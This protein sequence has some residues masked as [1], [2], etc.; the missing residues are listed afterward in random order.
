MAEDQGQDKTEQP[1][2]RKLEEAVEQGNVAKSRELNSVAVLV[3]VMIA[4]KAFS[5]YTANALKGFMTTTYQE[6]SFISI[7]VESLPK[8]TLL[9]LSVLAKVTLPII[10]VVLVFAMAANYAQ[11]GFIF[12]KKALLPKFSKINPLSGLKR[13]FSAQSLVELLKGIIKIV[14]L[15]FISYL[16]IRKHIPE[17]IALPA[18][19]AGE[20]T[21]FFI[22]ILFE[23]TLKIT[24]ALLVMAVADFAWQKYDHLKQLKMTKQEVK[25]EMKQQEGNPLVKSKIRS[26]QLSRARSRMLKAV[27]EATVV[28]TNPTTY[29]VALKYDPKSSSD[30][31]RVVA[32][33]MRKLAERIKKIAAENQ[34]PV[35]ENKPLAR[36]L[37]D[38]CP[39][40]SEIPMA[41]YQAVAEVLSRI[42]LKN[43][44]KMPRI[45]AI[46]G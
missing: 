8:Q 14:I 10:L 19:S 31:P 34:I 6:I 41:Y 24:I 38:T 45:G 3:G 37:Y 20:I 39:V 11:V 25:D 44:N 29:A 1:S 46:N 17:Y 42:F 2:A 9:V 43:K 28:V 21:S 32:K 23:M 35:I 13:M 22:S 30:A 15:A 33:G 18:H 16:V 26:L 12:A 4:F 40:G 27:P 7:T 36:G 5:G